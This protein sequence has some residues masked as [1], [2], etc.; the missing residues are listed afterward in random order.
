[1]DLTKNSPEAVD[2]MVE[3]IK[4]KLRMMNIG[5]IKSDSF[6]AEMH[7]ELH[8]LYEMVMR[9]QKFSPSEMEAIAE[10]LGRLR[11]I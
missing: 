11:N 8:E 3:A 9:K 4:E 1:M 5:A 6:N 10:E 2:F 7:E